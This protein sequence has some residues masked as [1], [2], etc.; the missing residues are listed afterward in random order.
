MSFFEKISGLQRKREQRQ[1]QQYSEIVRSLVLGKEPDPEEVDRILS[2]VG[3]TVAEFQADVEKGHERMAM[4]A[5]AN[6]LPNLQANRDEIAK[7]INAVDTEFAKAEKAHD[8]ARLPLED[9]LRECDEAIRQATR[10]REDLVVTCED[11][12]LLGEM[13]HVESEL[14]RLREV[15]RDLLSKAAYFENKADTERNMADKETGEEKNERIAKAK[16]FS[17]EAKAVR[18]RMKANDKLSEGLELQRSEIEQRMR[19]F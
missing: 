3:I 15:N 1:D 11:P 12:V 16:E 8:D 19:E 18:K 6:S 7:Q 4:H 14:E 17:E 10:A 13:K 2:E 9:R 5:L